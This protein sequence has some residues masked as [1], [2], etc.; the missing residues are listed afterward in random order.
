MIFLR[1]LRLPDGGALTLEVSSRLHFE[2][3]S[4]PF[5]GEQGPWLHLGGSM[6]T[7]FT[8]E[9]KVDVT[10]NE[11]REILNEALRTAAQMLFAQAAM[12]AQK[13]PPQIAVRSE[14]S[15]AGVQEL[16]LHDGEN[17]DD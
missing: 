10:S 3:E 8:L 5:F 7:T 6:R 16:K 1:T 2:T 13:R 9:L 14:N 15:F 4:V 12:L 11:Q 17:D